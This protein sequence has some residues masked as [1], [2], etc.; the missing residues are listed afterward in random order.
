MNHAAPNPPSLTLAVQW[1][2]R[3]EALR[4]LA[5]GGS[6]ILGT[7][8][9]ALVLLV[10]HGVAHWM[11]HWSELRAMPATALATGPPAPMAPTSEWR[12]QLTQLLADMSLAHLSQ[13][14]LR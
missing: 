4:Q 14:S 9:L 8:P 1:K 10:R 11:R 2:E 13:E 3:Y 12:Q 5:V 6:P 7:D